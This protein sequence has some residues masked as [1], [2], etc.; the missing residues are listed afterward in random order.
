MTS[1]WLRLGGAFVSLTVF[2]QVSSVPLSQDVTQRIARRQHGPIRDKTEHGDGTATSTNWSGYAVLGSGFT[3]AQGTWVVPT[4]DCTGVTQNQYAS[5][6]VGLDGYSS[7]TV[8]QTGT[9]SDCVGSTPNYYAWYE[10]Y[11]APS[12][13]VPNLSVG[14]GHV[15][16]ASVVYDTNTGVFTLTITDTNTGQT[17]TKSST[18]SGA[19]RS[20]AE[21]ILEAPCCT[22]GGMLPLPNFGTAPFGPTFT[23]QGNNDATDSAVSGVISAFSPNW[24]VITKTATST[25]PQTSTCS[26]LHTDGAS[27]TCTYGAPASGSGGG[28]HHHH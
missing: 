10:F 6:W 15:I 16:T 1:K 13:L 4:V 23:A 20:S 17:F 2:A 19:Q 14:P 5:S 8:E 21:W 9:D 25:S 11:P 12:F 24:W 22:H 18:V 26:T 7:N 3:T 27:F 28:G